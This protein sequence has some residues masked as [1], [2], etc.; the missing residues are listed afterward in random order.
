[1]AQIIIPYIV[2]PGHDRALRKL[3]P[4]L[5]DVRRS[6]DNGVLIEW[7]RPEPLPTDEDIAAALIQADWDGVRAKRKRL[8][9]ATDIVA[10]RYFK[11]GQSF[12]AD[13]A[14]Y[15]QALRDVTKQANPLQVEWPAA[16]AVP[17]GT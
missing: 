12:P 17:S 14:I 13:M 9:D 5:P 2:L 4:G 6:M 11:A 8:L 3:F 10:L 1:M 16:P 7:T 15:T